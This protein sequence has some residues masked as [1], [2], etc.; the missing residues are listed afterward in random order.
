M[1]SSSSTANQTYKS[2]TINNTDINTLNKSVN[3]FVTTNV[4]KQAADCHT[5]SNQQNSKTF[6]NIKGTSLVV[7]GN[8]SNKL[9]L[10]FSC[11]ASSNFQSTLNQGIMSEYLAAVK[12]NVSTEAL[13]QMNASA[14][15]SNK[16][17]FGA[18]GGSSDATTNTNVDLTNINN[19]TQNI[20][21]VIETTIANNTSMESVQSCIANVQQS[22]SNKFANLVMTG[23]IIDMSNMSNEAE[24][25]TE[26]ILTAANTSKST[27][28]IASK[29][30]ITIANDTKTKSEGS[31]TS[32]TTSENVS[33]GPIQ[34]LGNAVSGIINSIGGIFG[35]MIM[36]YAC[37]AIVCLLPIGIIFFFIFMGGDMD[38]IKDMIPEN[39]NGDD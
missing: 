6:D 4:M 37:I 31:I 17:G 1:G 29:L 27:S 34:D 23:A 2:T 13:A 12:N 39:N 21:N 9:N 36:A 33:T 10:N 7:G 14:A 35:N 8:M 5:S 16:S 15:S 32:K 30:G 25:A 19:T 28:E 22:N 11:V 20:Q 26:C 38:E 3:N 18:T 24:I